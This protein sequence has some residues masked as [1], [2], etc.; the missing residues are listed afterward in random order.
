MKRAIKFILL[1]ALILVFCGMAIAQDKDRPEEKSICPK[2]KM[3]KDCF[4]CHTRGDFKLKEFP[5]DA[6]L[7][8]PVPGLKIRGDRGHYLMDTDISFTAAENFE[9]IF[10]YL[11]LHEI[12]VLEVEILS[13]GGGVFSAWRIVSLMDSWKAAGNILEMKN[14]SFAASAAFLIFMNGSKGYRKISPYAQLMWHEII[15]FQMFVVMNV[16]DKEEESRLMRK[17]QDMANAYLFERS[18]GRVTKERIDEAI[19]KKEWWLSGKEA[20][21]LGFADELILGKD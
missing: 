1:A 17:W 12:H 11:K 14:R 20:F 7:T 15:S 16:S 10:A 8:Y 2:T 13:P 4:E 5:A 19:R 18:G 3:G 21:D 9:K 6:H